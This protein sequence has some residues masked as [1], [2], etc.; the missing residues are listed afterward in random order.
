[1]DTNKLRPVCSCLAL[2]IVNRKNEQD[3]EI[4]QSFPVIFFLAI[5]DDRLSSGNHNKLSLMSQ[6]NKGSI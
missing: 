3:T 1:M 4:S 6:L 5:N 2:I